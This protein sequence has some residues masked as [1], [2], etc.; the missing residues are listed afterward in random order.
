[1]GSAPAHL[2]GTIIMKFLLLAA[3]LASVHAEANPAFTYATG[4][5]LPYAIGAPLAYTTHAVAP[6][7]YTAA[8]GC[9]ND[10][11][12]VVP[13]AHGGLV[14]VVPAA[15]VA[16]AEPAVEEARKKR[17]ATAEAEAKAWLFY[18]THGYWP[19]GYG[20]LA[21]S[22]APY[23]YAHHYGYYGRGHHYGY[24]ARKKREATAE[25]DAEA[26]PE[27]DPWLLYGGYG[28]PYGGYYGYGYHH[29]P[30]AYLGGC[31]NYLG[32]L[33]PCAGR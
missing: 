24:Y 6:V 8:A 32:G 4:Y 30:Y 31:R 1:M 10:A 18:R 33:V 29:A 21:Y 27:A 2:L 17:E 22:Y 23:A 5:H 12:A 28:L 11:G 7:V 15:P 20:H 16:A 26:S 19:V 13:C 9:Q 3:T 25:A 14:G